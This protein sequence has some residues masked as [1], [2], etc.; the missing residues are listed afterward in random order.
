M[1][2]L[3]MFP[4]GS[5]LLPGA[6]LPLL[7][8]EPRY[9]ALLRD[10]LAAE[11][12]DFGVV[13][14]ERGS[15][16]GGGEHRSMIGAVARMIQVAELDDGR[17]AVVCVGTRRIRVNAW[18]P[19]DPYPL[20]DVD[21]WPDDWPEDWRDDLESAA[22]LLP[23]LADLRARVR[24]ACALAGEL[25]DGVFGDRLF[26]DGAAG[27][28]DDVSDDPLVA[29][30]QLA[31]LAP[32]GPADRFALLRAAGPAARIARLDEVM[33]DLEALLQFRLGGAGGLPSEGFGPG[34]DGRPR[35]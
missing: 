27:D 3:P 32:I 26:G 28:T 10:C 11:T 20:A 8:F 25:G 30:Y 16:V 19:D 31:A 33:H 9:R 23:Q 34:S 15:E 22:T 14:I 7:V 5:V 21:E 35:T 2:V 13:L 24:R 29:S 18:L 1:A 6:V 17:F 4:L 12:P